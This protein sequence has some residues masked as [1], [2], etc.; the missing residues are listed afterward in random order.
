MPI[1]DY[2]KEDKKFELIAP[3]EYQVILVNM[4]GDVSSDKPYADFKFQVLGTDE[5][6]KTIFKRYYLTPKTLEKFIPWQMG[7]LGL[8]HDIKL[9][10]T[11]SQAVEIMIDKSYDLIGKNTYLAEISVETYEGKN[12]TQ[13]RNNIV[14][15][16]NLGELKTMMKPDQVF[17]S[18]EELPF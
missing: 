11:F 10:D 7:V 4:N 15:T 17:D 12:G 3:G 5:D 1:S 14:L 13:K 16:D 6:K 8:W 2:V 18:S 9:A